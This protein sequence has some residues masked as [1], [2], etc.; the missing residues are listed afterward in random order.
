MVLNAAHFLPESGEVSVTENPS[1]TGASPADPAPIDAKSNRYLRLLSYARPYRG[2][3]LVVG[4]I[5]IIGSAVG[6]LQP[7]PMQVL[8]DHVLADKEKPTWLARFSASVATSKTQLLIWVA[9]ASFVL[10]VISALIDAA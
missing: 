1:I 8:V 10:F 2:Q 9:V 3:W 6:V 4:L 5:L 7:W